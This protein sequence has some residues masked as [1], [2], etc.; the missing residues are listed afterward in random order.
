MNLLKTLIVEDNAAFRQTFVEAL[1]KRFALMVVD[2]ALN[3]T[4]ALEKIEA[5]LPDLVF[6]DIRLP[7]KNG[8]ELTKT[9]KGSHPEIIVI[10]LTDYDLPEYREAADRGGADG[11]M[12][13]GSLSLEEIAGFIQSIFP[14]ADLG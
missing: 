9:I 7:G 1:A 3:G 5:F 12:P 8:L 4:G 10:I 13:K 2:M 14:D 6:M 11:F